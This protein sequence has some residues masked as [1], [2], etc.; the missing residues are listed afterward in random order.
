MNYESLLHADSITVKNIKQVINS[1]IV[2]PRGTTQSSLCHAQQYQISPYEE[3]SDSREYQQML[4]F[5]YN[6]YGRFINNLEEKIS[7]ER[8]DTETLRDDLKTSVRSILPVRTAT[9]ES[10]LLR[11]AGGPYAW[12]LPNGQIKMINFPLCVYEKGCVSMLYWQ[13]FRGLTEPIIGTSSMNQE[14]WDR[15]IATGEFPAETREPCVNCYRFYFANI[16]MDH[17]RQLMMTG[18]NLIKKPINQSH[19]LSIQSMQ[20]YYNLMDQ[21][22]GYCY[23]YIESN[24]IGNSIFQPLVRLNCANIIVY[25]EKDRW[26]FDQSNLIWNP[27]IRDHLSPPRI[28]EQI[29]HFLVR[30]KMV[31]GKDNV[32]IKAARGAALVDKLISILL[33]R[34]YQIPKFITPK[35]YLPIDQKTKTWDRNLILDLMSNSTDCSPLYSFLCTIVNDAMLEIPTQETNPSLS[36]SRLNWMNIQCDV[37]LD[38]LLFRYVQNA[39]YFSSL[40]AVTNPMLKL[41]SKSI[42]LRCNTRTSASIIRELLI[43]RWVEK[44]KGRN[45]IKQV[46]THYDASVFKHVK[47]LTLVALLGNYYHVNPSSRPISPDIRRRLYHIFTD[48]YYDRWCLRLFHHCPL[49]VLTI[50][51]SYV[52]FTISHDPALLANL[53]DLLS[54]DRFKELS[55]LAADEVR[56]Y[57]NAHLCNPNSLLYQSLLN[58]PSLPCHVQHLYSCGCPD[59][60]EFK[61]KKKQT[62][63]HMPCPMKFVGIPITYTE[64]YQ[65]EKFDTEED[66]KAG[67]DWRIQEEHLQIDYLIEPME[68]KMK[69]EIMYQRKHSGPTSIAELLLPLRK[70]G[71]LIPVLKKQHSIEIESQDDS[72]PEI[73]WNDD[74]DSDSDLDEA[75]DA[76]DEKRYTLISAEICRPF[77]SLNQ[78]KTVHEIVE[79]VGPVG[80]GRPILRVLDFFQFLGVSKPPIDYC[81]KLLTHYYE[82]TMKIERIKLLLYHLR[83]YE[84]HLYNLLQISSDLLSQCNRK[85]TIAELPLHITQAQITT[86][87]YRAGGSILQNHLSFAFCSICGHIYSNLL[88][89]RGV[90]RCTFKFGL[91]NASLSYLNHTLH[92]SRKIP[93][94]N[95]Q[96][97][98]CNDINQTLSHIPMIGKLLTYKSKQIMICPNCGNLTC[99]DGRLK[100][101]F[102]DGLQGPLC[103]KCQNQISTSGGNLS[104]WEYEKMYKLQAIHCLLCPDESNLIEKS[105]QAFIYPDQIFICPTHQKEI[106]ETWDLIPILAKEPTKTREI[107]M[108]WKPHPN[109]PS[110]LDERDEQRVLDWLKKKGDLVISFR[111]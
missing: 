48:S 65:Q 30:S 95:S 106:I 88:D 40:A 34:P 70:K 16:H 39:S 91:R 44:K 53:K 109:H 86:L 21:P 49:M 42:F 15:L 99:F 17:C 101:I 25:K 50:I 64:L 107:L 108:G 31:L 33:Q 102:Y 97:K 85:L 67:F 76:E 57:F 56:Q 36:D 14:Q 111:I 10:N 32:Y 69:N 22:E 80:F 6:Y 11:Q 58:L 43:T 20:K 98:S 79:S 68:I 55:E 19:A 62:C 71:P 73:D 87:K 78:F 45:G 47:S 54:F 66:T 92:C 35:S 41:M 9:L 28:G 72:I 103:F 37:M 18:E 51:R 4:D 24:T 61:K 8:I 60:D 75:K 38:P 3:S 89:K 52:I 63:H 110:D 7:T 1:G 23:E 81:K 46:I 82:S 29:Q 93:M 5:H 26:K 96:G 84:P 83:L 13:C 100:Y 90:Y 77:I 105:E 94:T 12:D 74:S 27:A 2:T 59:S 104:P